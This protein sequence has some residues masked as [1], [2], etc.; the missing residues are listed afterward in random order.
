MIII[1]LIHNNLYKVDFIK[2]NLYYNINIIFCLLLII[3]K[4]L[5]NVQNLHLFFIF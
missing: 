3:L 1:Y 4:I 5:N 2:I